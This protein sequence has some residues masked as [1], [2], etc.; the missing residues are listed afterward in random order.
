[1][2]F[3]MIW[4]KRNKCTFEGNRENKE[5]DHKNLLLSLILCG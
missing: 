5:T 3:K 1:M 2:A 4:Q